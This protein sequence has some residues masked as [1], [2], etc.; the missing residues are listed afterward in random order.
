MTLEYILLLSAIQG[1]TE[2][3]PVSSSA[4]L[5]LLPMLSGAED[6]GLFIDVAAHVG[7]L[8]AVTWHYRGRVLELLKFRDR[9]LMTRLI[10]ATLPILTL[11]LF[12]NSPR[13]VVVIAVCSIIFGILL[14]LADK[15]GKEGR[16]VSLSTAFITGL[17]Q[18]LALVP[19]VSRSGITV[20]AM[21]ARGVGRTEALDFA[22]LM[23]MPAIAA[24]GGW[25]FLQAIRSPEVIN[26]T[27]V[28][29]VVATSAIF[30]LWAIR[31]MLRFARKFSFAGFAFYR[32]LLGVILL[33]FFA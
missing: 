14:W 25:E 27:A 24:A 1:L 12:I 23:S 20:S 30:S 11:G 26:W 9:G 2:Y 10:L 5:A 6:Q 22:F 32:V 4:H 13:G 29:L 19:G 18:V 7:S 31:F 16:E 28:G 17:A 15:Y 21:R 3:I 33:A 8:M